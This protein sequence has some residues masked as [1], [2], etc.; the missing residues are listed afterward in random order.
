MTEIFYLCSSSVRQIK[1][2]NAQLRQKGRVKARFTVAKAV[3]TI[4][5]RHAV[6][7]GRQRD[8]TRQAGRNWKVGMLRLSC[9]TD[10]SGEE[11]RERG[12]YTVY[13]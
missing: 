9:T 6:Q 3:R 10:W 2:S 4:R 11:R 5:A 1:V 7:K 13:T 8:I 12:R